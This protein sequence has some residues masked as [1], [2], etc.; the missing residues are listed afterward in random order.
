MDDV[1]ELIVVIPTSPRSSKQ[2]PDAKVIAIFVLLAL[3]SWIIRAKL[4]P[5]NPGGGLSGQ[6]WK[7]P[8]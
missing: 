6:K 3:P 7:Y 8:T 1:I 2:S 4:G 5:N